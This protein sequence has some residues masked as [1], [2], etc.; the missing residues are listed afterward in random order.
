MK[1]LALHWQIIL[2]MLVG[3][4]LGTIA[5]KTGAEH[6]VSFIK[7]WIEP[8][9][10]IFINLLK[11]IAVPLI[12]ASLIKGV[13]D[14]QDISK[15]SKIGG[16]TIVFFILT[17]LV[18]VTIGVVAVNTIK[19]GTAVSE[20]TRTELMRNLREMLKRRLVL[21]INSRKHHHCNFL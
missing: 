16:R 9:G 2:G 11:M 15:L 18:A 21:Q 7:S 4:L 17:T 12:V 6:G 14:L 13:A 8:W 1:K 19:P 10:T 5:T 20:T 3:I